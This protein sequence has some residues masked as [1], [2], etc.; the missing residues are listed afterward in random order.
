MN[1]NPNFILQ[2]DRAFVGNVPTA[3]ALNATTVLFATHPCTLGTG[4]ASVL[5]T[6]TKASTGEA[7][8]VTPDA[9]EEL[10]VVFGLHDHASAANGVRAYYT[11]DGGATWHETDIKDPKNAATIGSAAAIQ[12]PTLSAGQEWAEIFRIGRYRGFAITY[13]A[14]ATGPTAGT[15]WDVTIGVKYAPQGG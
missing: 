11:N 12:V 15:G 10:E 8:V 9:I 2:V 13:T 6:F 14:G 3:P 4:G 5:S 7:V 1:T